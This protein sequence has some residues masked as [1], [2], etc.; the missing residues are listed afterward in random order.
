MSSQFQNGRVIIDEKKTI[1]DLKMIDDNGKAMKNFQVEAL[2][3][4]QE[5]T[6]LNQLFFSKANMNI[7]QDGIRYNVYMKT[8]KKHIIGKQSEVELEIIMRSIYLQHSPNLPNNIK[9]QIKYLNQLIID[10]CIE[11]I[12]PEI[13]QYYGYLKEIEFMPTPIDLPLNLSSKG[14]RTLRSVTTTF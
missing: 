1:K 2:Y 7:I 6:Q 10:W 3:G 12:I 8:D 14:S 9:E 13:Y 4:I 5:T 11:T